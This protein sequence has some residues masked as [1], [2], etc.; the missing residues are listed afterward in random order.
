[1][2]QAVCVERRVTDKAT[3]ETHTDVAYA[4]TSLAPAVATPAQLLVL[5]REHWHIEIV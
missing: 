2:A 1:M 4:V 5:W 3:G